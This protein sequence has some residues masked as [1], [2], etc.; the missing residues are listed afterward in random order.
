MNG[1][2]PEAQRLGHDSEAIAG[3]LPLVDVLL[4]VLAVV[5]IL[6][7]A[8][9]HTTIPMRLP[10]VPG[11]GAAAPDAEVRIMVDRTGRISVDRIEVASHRLL[12]RLRLVPK[13]SRLVIAGD[14]AADYGTVAR[15]LQIVRM[16]GHTDA[17]LLAVGA[18][19]TSKPSADGSAR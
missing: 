11:R 14:A 9:P 7:S 1:R 13:G 19:L 17:R 12:E 2:M 16:A 4:A 6:A 8:A 18:G 5:M 15:L 3:F 10:E